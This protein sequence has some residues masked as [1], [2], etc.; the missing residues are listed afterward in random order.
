MEVNYLKQYY[1]EI[2]KGNI[3]V[4]L[5][6]K[7]ELQKL[8]KDLDNPQYRYDTSES[9]LRIEFMEN[10]CLQSKKPFYNVPMQLLLWEKAFIE[11]VYSFK[12]FDEELNRQVGNFKLKS[13]DE[14]KVRDALVK[15]RGYL[16]EKDA[17]ERS[18]SVDPV[19]QTYT[20]SGEGSEKFAGSPDDISKG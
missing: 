8:I 3:I 16:G 20:I 11:V 9:H 5:E 10:L 4:G 6:L 2:Q 19:S 7:T 15:L 13:K 18:F 12:F 14:R 1:E 17:T